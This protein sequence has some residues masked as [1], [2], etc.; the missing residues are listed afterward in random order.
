ME[1]KS[2]FLKEK[3]NKI[4]E[5][6]T[7]KHVLLI[8]AVYV[9]GTAILWVCNLNEGIP[10]STYSIIT[11]AILTFYFVL[12]ASASLFARTVPLTQKRRNKP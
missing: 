3:I 2:N 9:L 1:N 10:F 12:F 7:T 11:Y 5:I 8:L 4:N 6:V